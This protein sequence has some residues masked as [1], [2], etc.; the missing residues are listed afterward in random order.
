MTTSTTTEQGRL[1]TELLPRLYTGEE[2]A[3]VV[4][5]LCKEEQRKINWK[6]LNK[7]VVMAHAHYVKQL[8]QRLLNDDVFIQFGG[9]N[10][11]ASTL[12]H[13]PAKFRSVSFDIPQELYDYMKAVFDRYKDIIHLIGFSYDGSPY[14]QILLDNE[15]Y[16]RRNGM[17]APMLFP[18]TYFSKLNI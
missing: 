6:E 2:L 13:Q 10:F 12:Q 8:R 16:L 18:F 1:S 14:L 7:L 5:M 17:D 3:T 9:N 11:W 15:Q 4:L